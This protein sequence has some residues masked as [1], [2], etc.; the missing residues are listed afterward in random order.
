[1]NNSPHRGR[2][3][4]TKFHSDLRTKKLRLGWGTICMTTECALEKKRAGK[5][6]D[7]PPGSKP[8]RPIEEVTMRSAEG[9][10]SRITLVRN[11][12]PFVHER[13]TE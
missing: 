13:G 11:R 10:Y 12:E 5:G 8:Q 7:A 1:V 4:T 9:Q 2:N 6:V 3:W